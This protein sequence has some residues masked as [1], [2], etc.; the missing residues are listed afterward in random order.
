MP[1]HRC[2]GEDCQLIT[3][4][5]GLRIWFRM[6]DGAPTVSCDSLE[7]ADRP[8][9]FLPDLLAWRNCKLSITNRYVLVKSA[10]DDDDET[11]RPPNVTD[12]P[13]SKQKSVYG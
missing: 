6:E 4:D 10:D 9:I 12:I 2:G 5:R 11:R 1:R 13:S 8:L 7:D 3:S